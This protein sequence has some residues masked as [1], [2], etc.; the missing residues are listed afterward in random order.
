MSILPPGRNLKWIIEVYYGRN[1]YRKTISGKTVRQAFLLAVV[2]VLLL[3]CREERQ[4]HVLPHEKMVHVLGEIYIQEEKVKSLS[5]KP[6]SADRLLNRMKQRLL[7]SL[8]IP[9]TVL[10]QSLD[11]YWDNPEE[12]DKIYAA[13]VDSL[14]LREQALSIPRTE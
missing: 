4:R 7:D 8:H 3:A 6:D 9:D 10:R 1:M 13:L 5:L 14:N 2:C 11:Y 12:M